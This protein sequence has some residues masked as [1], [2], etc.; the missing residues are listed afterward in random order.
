[1]INVTRLSRNMSIYRLILTTH[2]VN[3]TWKI[4]CPAIKCNYKFNAVSTQDQNIGHVSR[5]DTDQ[6]RQIVEES[7]IPST[8]VKSQVNGNDDR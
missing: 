8:R 1:M 4:H 5:R 3:V 6:P 2:G 7:S